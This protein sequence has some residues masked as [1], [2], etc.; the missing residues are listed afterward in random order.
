MAC[1]MNRH[2]VEHIAPLLFWLIVGRQSEGFIIPFWLSCG[3]GSSILM[4]VADFLTLTLI[5]WLSNPQIFDTLPF[6]CGYISGFERNTNGIIVGQASCGRWLD[7]SSSRGVLR[8]SASCLSAS[9]WERVHNTA[10]WRSDP[11]TDW[12]C[13]CMLR[14]HSGCRPLQG[15]S[16]DCRPRRPDLGLDE[17]TRCVL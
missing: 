3:W 12:P 2:F 8:G 1:R 5:F 15:D 10:V 9:D 11:D 6:G 7:S 13:Y 14:N 16:T 17:H 4:I